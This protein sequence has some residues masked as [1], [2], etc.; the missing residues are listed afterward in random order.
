[1]KI[2]KV[3]NKDTGLYYKSSARDQIT[4]TKSGKYWVSKGACKNHINSLNYN[5]YGVNLLRDN[6]YSL[7]IDEFDVT[8]TNEIDL[9]SFL[10]DNDPKEEYLIISSLK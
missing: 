1:M 10:S 4:F 7:V 3:K 5:Y 6:L 2:F 8:P 9:L